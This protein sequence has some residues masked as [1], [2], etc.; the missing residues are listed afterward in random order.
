V[1]ILFS[2]LQNFVIYIMLALYIHEDY[3]ASKKDSMSEGT[4]F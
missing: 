2:Y 3:K 1:E 4:E